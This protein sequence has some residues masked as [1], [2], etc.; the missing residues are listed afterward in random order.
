MEHN[1]E[2]KVPFTVIGSQFHRVP[3][4]CGEKG[5]SNSGYAINQSKR[6]AGCIQILKERSQN[7]IESMS[8]RNET[9]LKGKEG[10]RRVYL[11]K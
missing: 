9:V 6:I 3:V 10:P 1:S 8:R 2:I 4:E 7:I 5:D 11:I